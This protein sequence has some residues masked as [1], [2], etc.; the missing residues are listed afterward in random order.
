[1]IAMLV[2]MKPLLGHVSMLYIDGQPGPIRNANSQTGNG[3]ASVAGGCGGANTF[4][5][6]G[7]GL[8]I[9]GSKVKLNINYAAGH[10]S[11]QNAFRMA[12]A[13]GDDLSQDALESIG[14]VLTAAQH[15]CTATA[16]GLPADYIDNGKDGGVAAPNAI[17][18][19][20]YEVECELPLQN[21]AAVQQ[22]TVALIDQRDWGGC[23][24]VD[25]Q[26]AT[27]ALPPS[28]PP[29]PLI[30]NAGS[31]YFTKAGIIDTSASSFTCCGLESGYLEVPSY[32]LSASEVTARVNAQAIGCR[33]SDDILAPTTAS[34]EINAPVVMKNEGSS[35]FEGNVQMAGQP[36][37]FIVEG[38]AVSFRN[39]GDKQPIICDGETDSEAKGL[40]LG[41]ND[42]SNTAAIAGV[43]IAVIG[44]VVLLGCGYWFCCR[45]S[46]KSPEFKTMGGLAS[47]PPPPMI[48][49]AA[50]ALPPGWTCGTDPTTGRVYYINTMSGT[51][52]W[53]P[54]ANV[55]SAAC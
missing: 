3:R 5:A 1:M 2:V 38:K 4:G 55:G 7:K 39:I 34:F 47:P 8:L 33:E 20:G 43:T 36:F 6:N 24:D 46:Q 19:G 31:Y 49:A 41:G 22:C 10:Q 50:P 21:N 25:L 16:G 51:S 45:K 37:T 29:A 53:E 42:G 44:A 48:G 23:V 28:P 13:C 15:S 11:A 18:T 12:Y 35:K 30:D 40:R 9:D 17:I 14:S 52:Q 54:P 26:P 32:L 27:V